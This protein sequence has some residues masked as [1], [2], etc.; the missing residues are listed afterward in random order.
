MVSLD[1]TG[2][3]PVDVLPTSPVMQALPMIQIELFKSRLRGIILG[4]AVGDAL[5]LPLENLGPRRAAKLFPG[6]LKHHFF[7]KRGMVS[8]DPD[9]ILF[10]GQSLL[11]HPDS[12]GDFR[13]CGIRSGHAI[14]L[15]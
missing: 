14:P 15:I 13:H 11:A 8:D 3:A 7:L 4:T 10:V 5:G 6:Q 2:A 9:H 12:R 1:S